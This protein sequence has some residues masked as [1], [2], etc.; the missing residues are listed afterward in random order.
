MTQPSGLSIRAKLSLWYGLALAL[1]FALL[2]VVLYTVMAR[3]L[4][5]QLDRSLE[6]AAMGAVG[7]LRHH[8]FGP[9]LP[10]EDLASE[11]PELAVLDKF[12]QIF[13]PAGQVTIQSP[14]VRR[15]DIPLSPNALQA[16]LNGE[17]T[18]ESARFRGEAPIRI[19]SVPIRRDGV[20]VNIVQ[21]GTS[22]QPVEQSLRRLLAVILGAAPFALLLAL[23]GG[24]LL[25]GRALRPVDAITEAARR[26][27]A[28]DLSQRLAIP[29]TTDE[30]GRLAA[31]FNEM[32]ARLDASFQQVRRFS[33]DASHELRT[34][35]TVMKGEAELALRRPRSAEDYRQ[36]LESS[37]EEIDRLSRI[38]DEL[39]FLSRADLGEVPL[40]LAPVR[41]DQLL[42]DLQHQASVLGQDRH[43]RIAVAPLEPVTVMG[44][45]LRLRELLLNLLD[46]A[47]TYSHAGG[48]VEV[49][50]S[51]AGQ[52]ARLSVADHG[53]GIRP[54]E[55]PHI[56]D[57]FYR[58]DAAR[59]HSKKGSGLGL[60]ICKWIAESHQGR[61]EVESKQGEGSRFTVILP[62]AS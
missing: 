33:A 22:M 59:D 37:L 14:N 10:F 60:A 52:T 39:L 26:I 25:A 51:R 34:P 13:S 27:A 28:G 49:Q 56:F 36:V 9:A 35:L 50:L 8:G 54:E 46:N 20:L 58:T 7:A 3:D 24:W 29:P 45:E 47:V 42:E 41:L 21:V 18:L 55:Q 40:K 31:T 62:V 57:R 48:Q 16:A 61:I 32:I 4:R 43:V 30:I 12:F 15:H 38:V 11:F 23:A 5:E 2:A 44:D 19:V 6:Q 17:A 1:T 53:I